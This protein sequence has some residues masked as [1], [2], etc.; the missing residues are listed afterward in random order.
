MPST[1]KASRSTIAICWRPRCPIRC[2]SAPISSRPPRAAKS[3]RTLLDA[4]A[5]RGF[6]LRFGEDETGFQMMYLRRGGGYYFNVGCSELIIS[7]KDQAPAICRHRQIRR[8]RRAAQGRQRSLPAEL[9]VLAT[10]YKN[11]QETA[12]RYLGDAIADTHRPGLGLRR[13]RRVAQHVAAHR[14]A[15]PVVHRRLA[16]AM[17]DYSRYLAIQIKALEEGLLAVGRS[18]GGA[19]QQQ[20]PADADASRWHRTTTRRAA[21][22]A[23]ARRRRDPGRSASPVHALRRWPPP[24]RRCGGCRM[25]KKGPMATGRTQTP[26]RNT[27]RSRCCR[28]HRDH[29]RRHD[30]G[31]PA[32]SVTNRLTRLMAPVTR[33][34]EPA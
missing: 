26:R 2:C 19:P 15:G 27:S 7:G 24:A 33:K 25:M 16:G 1:R 32:R 13:R 29:A 12:R 5:A 28:R 11:Q 20:V 34:R 9:L 23:D 3:T 4:L 21:P 31:A 30:A 18:A 6:R 14:A 10:G 8:R 22:P 17:P